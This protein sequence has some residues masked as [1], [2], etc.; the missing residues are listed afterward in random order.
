MAGVA[1]GLTGEWAKASAILGTAPA[2]LRLAMNRAVL[3][4]AQFMRA[5]IVKGFR[6]QA[7]GG[8]KFEPLAETT[9]AMRRFTGFSGT[10]ALLVR[11]DLRNSIKVVS[12]NSTL[13]AEAFVGVLRTAKSKDGKSLVNI[14][15]VHEFGAGP[16]AIEV[17]PAMRR[18]LGMVFSQEL[19]EREG[20]TGAGGTGIIIIKIPARPFIQPVIDKFFTGPKAAARFQKRVAVNMGGTF[21]VFGPTPL[22]VA[23]PR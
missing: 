7:P 3:Q 2:R 20:G 9:L 11:G 13:A 14:A 5:E 23:K 21:G 15:E 16:Y 12:R 8:K 4:E 19:G 10:K 1:I 18:F 22:R 6:T 17:T